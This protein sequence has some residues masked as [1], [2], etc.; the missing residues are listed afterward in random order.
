MVN[1]ETDLDIA[2]DEFNL[3]DLQR[4]FVQE[5][6]TNGNVATA[7]YK[8]VHSRGE[9]MNRTT[10]NKEAQK[11]RKHSAVDAAIRKII[12]HNMT[13]FMIT[14]ERILQEMA[15]VAFLDPAD[16]LEDDGSVKPIHEM[17]EEARRAIS[18]LD[19]SEIWDGP[20][21]ERQ[22]VGT[23]KKLGI[24]SKMKALSELARIRN[25]ITDK[26]ELSASDDLAQLLLKARRR[27]TT[28]SVESATLEDLF[29]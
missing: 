9:G 3:T 24:T 29:E 10:L 7:A 23:L 13:R 20:R 18:G 1:D 2:L 8:T 16:L 28:V 27:K 25:M 19:V 11:L 15:C 21:G 12:G 22:V 4:R 26:V 6:I 14:N 17:P 5:Y